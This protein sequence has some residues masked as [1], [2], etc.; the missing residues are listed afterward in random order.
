MPLECHSNVTECHLNVTWT[1]LEQTNK[2][3]NRQINKQT[4]SSDTQVT[5]NFHWTVTRMSLECQLVAVEWHS[6]DSQL[7]F[8]WQ[9]SDIPLVVNW[10][11]SGN[12]VTLQWLSIDSLVS[13]K[14]Q[15]SGHFTV[16][17]MSFLDTDTKGVYGNNTPF[18]S[19]VE[20]HSIGSQITFQWL[21]TVEWHSIGSRLAFQWQWHD[22]KGVY[23]NNTPFVSPNDS[24]VAV[25]W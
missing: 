16:T 23:G 12:W 6:I 17:G 21:L 24:S 7:T 8:H 1:S 25:K 9:L 19:Q 14:W 15:S 5:F 20:W 13:V 11:S 2:Q 4:N 3:I 22:T 10:H 18:V